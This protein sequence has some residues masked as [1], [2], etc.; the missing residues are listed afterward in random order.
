MQSTNGKGW[1][2][3]EENILSGWVSEL[4]KT[5]KKKAVGRWRGVCKRLKELSKKGSKGEADKTNDGLHSAKKQ[6]EKGVVNGEKA[7]GVKR[8]QEEGGGPGC[9]RKKD[10]GLMERATWGEAVVHDIYHREGQKFIQ[11]R[12]EEEERKNW[13]EP[14]NSY[15]RYA[16]HRP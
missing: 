16:T 13:T 14:P 3:A 10:G 9:L 1:K 11:R 8:A 4:D 7:R 5:I 12:W 15:S 2:L 6:A